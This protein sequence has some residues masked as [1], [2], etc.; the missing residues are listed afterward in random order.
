M[1][2]KSTNR[3]KIVPSA[4]SNLHKKRPGPL[5]LQTIGVAPLRQAQGRDFRKEA[6]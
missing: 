6:P 4:E 5:I 1:F 2:E 3:A